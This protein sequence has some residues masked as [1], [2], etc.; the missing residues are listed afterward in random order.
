MPALACWAGADAASSTGFGGSICA[1]CAP[2]NNIENR[3]NNTIT[4]ER[5]SASKAFFF[6]ADG[7]PCTDTMPSLEA[8]QFNSHYPTIDLRLN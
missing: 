2:R 7:R 6:L 8:R 3:N 5:I 4:E 1:A